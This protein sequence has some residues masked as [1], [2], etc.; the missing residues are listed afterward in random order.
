MYNSCTIYDTQGNEIARTDENRVVTDAKTG[1]TY[2][3]KKY[4]GLADISYYE[5]R[6]DNDGWVFEKERV[7]S[8]EGDFHD[9]EY[10]IIKCYDDDNMIYYG[11]GHSKIIGKYNGSSVGGSIAAYIC[12]KEGY[13]GYDLGSPVPAETKSEGSA[14]SKKQEFSLEGTFTTIIIFAIACCINAITWGGIPATYES[15]P[16]HGR[17]LLIV[18][19]SSFIGPVG[20][21]VWSFISVKKFVS[22]STLLGYVYLAAILTTLIGTIYASNV[23]VIGDAPVDASIFT[24]IIF[25][26]IFS[27]IAALV[28]SCICFIINS[29]KHH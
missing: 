8:R 26:I 13:F 24:Y 1:R 20:A 3:Y 23:N 4:F 7:R 14:S 15:F 12:L 19:V 10:V 6:S 18:V 27:P 2:D 22:F 11:D 17:Q 21:I 28:G 9:S 5:G 25:P 29:V 16:P